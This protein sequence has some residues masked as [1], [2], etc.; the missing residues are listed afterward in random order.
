[1]RKL[2]RNERILS[3]IDLARKQG[4]ETPALAFGAALAIHHALRC[5]DDKALEA[6]AIRQVYRDN[7]ASV[8]AV[9]THDVGCNGKRFPGLDPITD[10]QLISAISDAFRQYPQR[11]VAN[12]LDDLCIGA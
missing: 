4:I 5:K 2:Q 1:L 8:E 12:R 6:Q 10:A 9:L 7:G 3:S 11:D